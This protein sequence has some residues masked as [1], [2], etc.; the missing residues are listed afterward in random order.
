MFNSAQRGIPIQRTL[1]SPEAS[2]IRLNILTL[3]LALY[4]A[5]VRQSRHSRGLRRARF[6]TGS[7]FLWMATV[8]LALYAVTL[9]SPRS[10]QLTESVA[11]I[12]H[13]A[14]TDVDAGRKTLHRAELIRCRLVDQRELLAIFPSRSFAVLC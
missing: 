8:A 11:H 9:M 7:T 4:V 6:T 1:Q 5:P 2:I 13:D 12:L 10:G 14:E 3:S